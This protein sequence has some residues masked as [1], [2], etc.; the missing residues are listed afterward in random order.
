MI[1]GL[2]L[3][4]VSLRLLWLLILF[5]STNA[6][7]ARAFG[8]VIACFVLSIGT[9]F[10]QT[11][12][13]LNPPSSS[14]T[15]ESTADWQ[16]HQ[17][18]S[19]G[20]IV[21]FSRNG[22]NRNDIVLTSLATGEER[23]TRLQIEGA[24]PS[25]IMA[26]AVR[27]AHE[28]AVSGIYTSST[29]GNPASFLAIA[30]FRGQAS[31]IV[32]MGA[33]AANQLCTT[34]DGTTWVLGQD[35]TKEGSFWRNSNDTAKVPP[36][37]DY[38]ML[39]GYASD[40]T[41]VRSALKR[42][43]IQTDSQLY[44]N[45]GSSQFGTLVCG[46]SSVGVYLAGS[47]PISFQ[48]KWHELSLVNGSVR[49]W[50][51]NDAP[52]DSQLSGLAL[53]HGNTVVGSFRSFPRKGSSAGIYILALGNDGVA[54][55]VPTLVGAGSPA[56]DVPSLKVL[57]SNGTDLVYV[58]GPLSASS[59]SAVV[60]STPTSATPVLDIPLHSTVPKI[61]AS[62]TG[63]PVTDAGNVQITIDD[64]DYLL[65]G[66]SRYSAS[67]YSSAVLSAIA[68]LQSTINIWRKNPATAKERPANEYGTKNKVIQQENA[69]NTALKAETS[70]VACPRAELVNPVDESVRTFPAV[71]DSLLLEGKF[72]T[73]SLDSCR[74]ACSTIFGSGV[75]VCGLLVVLDPT[76]VGVAAAAACIVAQAAINIW[77]FDGC[78]ADT[79]CADAIQYNM[80]FRQ[81]R[82]S[83]PKDTMALPFL[84]RT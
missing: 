66:L 64:A 34:G 67:C 82:R 31:S 50:V 4:S 33:F 26:A 28:V 13:V 11:P 70:K 55:W 69:L 58:N 14:I 20:Y 40:G 16:R 61:D 54:K 51:V 8:T 49:S 60:L 46:S 71:Y 35:L 63:I 10:A 22:N 42:S 84:I 56:S 39:R 73:I 7:R 52:S 80:S 30:D 1:K 12:Q 24:T 59:Q 21:S 43:S 74:N 36:T 23:V 25:H 45:L 9:A 72:F 65:K 6:Y 18:I 19:N 62:Q 79:R 53:P 44:L 47:T 68:A 37:D 77:C 83:N 15:L 27:T 41:L 76:P 38:D 57:G 3:G 78:T 2:R 48:A 32:E 29:T 17:Q 81:Y 5:A 75:A